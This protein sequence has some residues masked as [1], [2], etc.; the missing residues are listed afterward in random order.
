MSII[1]FKLNRH[2]KNTLSEIGETT[3]YLEALRIGIDHGE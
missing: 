2:V 3:I 1:I